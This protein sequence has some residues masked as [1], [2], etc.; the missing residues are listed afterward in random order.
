[1]ISKFYLIFSHVLSVYFVQI[2][3]SYILEMVFSVADEI[4]WK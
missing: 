4:M 3:P 2:L 1:M